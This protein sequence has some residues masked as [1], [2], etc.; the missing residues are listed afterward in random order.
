MGEIIDKLKGKA[1]QVQ[2]KV[3]GDRAKQ[4]EGI[5]EEKKGEAKK[6]WEDVKHDVRDK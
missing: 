2:G 4:A 3:T 1:K 6:A 5:V